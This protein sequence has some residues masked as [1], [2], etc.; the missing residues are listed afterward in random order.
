MSGLI[1]TFNEELI[2]K[3]ED[4]GK[5]GLKPGDKCNH[6]LIYDDWIE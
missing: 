2:D 3:Y 4:E 1:I 5:Y 6:I